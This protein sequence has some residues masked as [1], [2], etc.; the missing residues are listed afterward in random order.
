MRNHEF[1]GEDLILVLDIRSKFVQESDMLGMSEGLAF[2][3]LSFF[4]DGE[5]KDQF[6]SILRLSSAEN[7]QVLYWL[8]A[9]QYLL[10]F[11]ATSSAIQEATL[12]L[13]DILQLPD[14]MNSAFSS[15]LHKDFYQFGN[16]FCPEER[17][18][19]FVDGLDPSNPALAA[20]YW[21]EYRKIT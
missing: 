11:N 10:R 18:F 8:G 4:L 13:R 17:C 9:V 6:R 2:L 7:G 19:T 20:R 16:N 1:S 21:E 3:A 5:A 14:D 15:R 12:A